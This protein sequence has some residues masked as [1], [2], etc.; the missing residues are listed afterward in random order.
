MLDAALGGGD[1]GAPASLAAQ[2]V[3]EARSTPSNLPK[4]NPKHHQNHPMDGFLG[5]GLWGG[6]RGLLW[7]LE[8]F[9]DPWVSLGT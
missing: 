7:C 5:G 8:G 6:F 2:A 3:Y 4:A 9:W 1:Y